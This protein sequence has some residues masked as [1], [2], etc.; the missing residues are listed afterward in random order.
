M[1]PFMQKN[2]PHTRVHFLRFGME[3]ED[4]SNS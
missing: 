2:H 3:I 4:L 1:Q